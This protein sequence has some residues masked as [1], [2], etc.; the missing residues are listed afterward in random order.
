MSPAVALAALA[1]LGALAVA[2]VAFWRWKLRAPTHE[3]EVHEAPTRDGWT[4]RLGRLRPRA[5]PRRPPVLLVHGIAM[6]RQAFDFGVERYSVAAFLARAGFDCF[7][8][9]LR[10]HGRSRRGPSRRWNLDTYLAEDLPAAFDAIRAATG[11]ERVLYVGH[12]QGA[13]LGMAACALHPSRVAALVSLAGPAHFAHQPRL[14]T[15]VKLRR[16]GAG[17]VLRELARAAAPFSGAWHPSLVELAINV[18]NVERPVYRRFLANALEDLQPGVL[19]Q[20]AAF[21]REDSFR[22]FDGRVDYRALLA[23]CR[24]PALF[25]AA[26]KD[27]LAPPAVVEASYAL[28]G[29]PK[30]L[31]SAGAD[32]GHSDLL[33]GRRAPEEV[34]PVVRAFLLAQ[35]SP[36]GEARGGPLPPAAPG[37]AADAGAPSR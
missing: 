36:G 8:L 14:A 34:F 24:Q 9:D 4:L 28:W 31:W 27:G 37:P 10:G 26:P 2:H 3:D 15:L 5:A 12:S 20:F 29:G 16:L 35:S 30:R 33:V 18:R 17:R 7:T 1:V 19:D 21:V 32:F 23:T 6:N 11:E 22:S 13:I 25:V